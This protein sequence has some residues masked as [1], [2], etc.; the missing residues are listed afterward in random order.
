MDFKT[1]SIIIPVFNEEKFIAECVHDVYQADSCGLEKEIII[2]NDG[3]IDQTSNILVQLKKNRKNLHIIN[4]EKNFGKGYSLKEG[5]LKT[6]G[7]IVIVQDSDREYNP[8]DYPILLEPFL[9]Y[10][11]DVVYGSRLVTTQPHRV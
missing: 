7:D 9:N 1:V 3:S 6:T 4:R 5:F 11:A 8:K 2:I 10:G